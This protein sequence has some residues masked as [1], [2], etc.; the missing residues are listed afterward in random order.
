MPLG[1]LLGCAFA[2]WS[3]SSA[4]LGLSGLSWKG[5]SKSPRGFWERF[6]TLWGSL[7]APRPLW[8]ALG[9]VSE[10]PV[11]PWTPPGRGPG[12]RGPFAR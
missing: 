8:G 2:V 3:P 12:R 10:A 11:P 7:G 4:T 6:G 5:L 9:A 1:G